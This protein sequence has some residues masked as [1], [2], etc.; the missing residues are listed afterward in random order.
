MRAADI[1][2]LFAALPLLDACGASS[3]EPP[4]APQP[5]DAFAVVPYPPP[6]ARVETL[7]KR[8]SPQAE[9]TDGQWSWDGARWN[10]TPGAWVDPPSGARFAPWALVLD[11]DGQYEFA[12]GSW[13]D[14]SG[15]ELQAPRVVDSAAGLSSGA[16]PN[17]R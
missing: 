4:R 15:R 14:A 11:R 10:W 7:P 17:C 8:P 9:W 13:R 5:P 6:A 12:P 1:A 2:L 16:A 3:H